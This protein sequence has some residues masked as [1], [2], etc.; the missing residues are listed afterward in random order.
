MGRVIVISGFLAFCPA[1][2]F[3]AQAP[4]H[5]ATPAV[6]SSARQVAPE[7]ATLVAP[8]QVFVAQLTRSSESSGWSGHRKAGTHPEK[9]TAPSPADDGFGVER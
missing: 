1:L 7:N 3:A 9:A 8:L 2:A 5:E 6:E 4:S